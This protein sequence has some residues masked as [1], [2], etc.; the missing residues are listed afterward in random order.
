MHRTAK[1]PPLPRY[2]VCDSRPNVE[3][4]GSRSEAEGTT[5]EQ[6]VA[7]PLDRHAKHLLLRRGGL[8]EFGNQRMV[9]M[10]AGCS[11]KARW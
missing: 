8:H 6:L 7:V 4:R 9:R 5:Q 1:Q 11:P 2:N 3:V 10:Q